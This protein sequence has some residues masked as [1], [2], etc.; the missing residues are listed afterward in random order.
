MYVPLLHP[1]REAYIQVYTPYYTPQGGIYQGLYPTS[2]PS[3]RHTRLYTPLSP[4]R[5]TYRAIY[6]LRYERE[7]C[8]AE[9]YLSLRREG[10]LL[11][12]E[13]SS[14]GRESPVAHSPASSPCPVS[15][16][17]IP[18][19]VPSYQIVDGYERFRRPCDGV[20]PCCCSVGYS[21]FTVG[22]S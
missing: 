9:R 5:E 15:L 7:A 11:R 8:C 16:L 2:H 18:P 14:L 6:T 13:P 3:G 10:N 1:L 22:H 12:R 4:L 21:R 17:G 19:Y 20:R